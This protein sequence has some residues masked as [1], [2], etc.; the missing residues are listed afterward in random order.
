MVLHWNLIF[1]LCDGSWDILS[2]TYRS[3][4]SKGCAQR[5]V[6]II[7]GIPWLP[8]VN[9]TTATRSKQFDP[10]VIKTKFGILT[11]R[12]RKDSYHCMLWSPSQLWQST[13]P[14]S[15]F[16]Q[17]YIA[18]RLLTSDRRPSSQ[19]GETTPPCGYRVI[20]YRINKMPQDW[21]GGGSDR[22]LLPFFAGVSTSL[23]CIAADCHGYRWTSF[24]WKLH[25]LFTL[26]QTQIPI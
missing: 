3:L 13:Q 9:S 1:P 20:K 4:N 6:R 24:L 21:K 10:V 8:P 12:R 2:D 26:S 18:L 19:T 16:L 5:P 15:Q 11:K 14:A 7:S 25:C 22:G 17:T 23:L